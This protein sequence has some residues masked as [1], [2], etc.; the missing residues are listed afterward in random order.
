MSV[1]LL[2]PQA[3]NIALPPLL[4][5]ALKQ[6]G[7]GWWGVLLRRWLDVVMGWS[8]VVLMSGD[9]NSCAEYGP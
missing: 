3:N 5:P 7:G 6:R 9:G 2:P 1:S 4:P 8:V